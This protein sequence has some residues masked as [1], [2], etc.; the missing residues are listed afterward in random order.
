MG[1]T[2]TAELF[3]C[4]SLLV[5]IVYFVVCECV[6]VCMSVYVYIFLHYFM[7]IDTLVW[8]NYNNPVS[9]EAYSLYFK[10]FSSLNIGS[11][12]RSRLKI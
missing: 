7:N 9:T 6:Y 4:G 3:W 12:G 8:V 2:I 5:S 10:H 1:R 11:H